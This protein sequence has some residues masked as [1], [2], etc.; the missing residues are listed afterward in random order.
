MRQEIQALE[1]LQHD[2]AVKQKKGPWALAA[3]MLGVEVL[4]SVSLILEVKKL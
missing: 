4:F 3:M 1:S 2:C